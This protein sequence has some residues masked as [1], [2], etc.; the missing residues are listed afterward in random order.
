M[1]KVCKLSCQ[2][3]YFETS[4]LGKSDLS[5]IVHILFE[6]SRLKIAMK[7]LQLTL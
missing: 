1:E 3:D 2:S 4:V 7:R 6:N 5:L